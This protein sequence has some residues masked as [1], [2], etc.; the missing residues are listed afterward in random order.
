MAALRREESTAG[1]IERIILLDSALA[2]ATLRLVNS[3]FVASGEPI[4]SVEQAIV[5][6]GHRELYRIAS[7]S[8]L[9]RWEEHHHKSLPWEPGDYTR[10]SLCTALGA[11]VIAEEG[12]RFDPPMSYTVGLVCDVG[13]LV[14]AYVCAP[15]YS[16]VSAAVSRENLSWDEAERSVFG[17]DNSEVGAR[18]LRSWRFPEPFAQ[19]VEF[20]LHPEQAPAEVGPLVAQLHAARYVA[21]CMGPGVTA[22]G[23]LFNLRGAFLTEWGYTSEM[24]ER[25][26]LEVRDRAIARL[27]DRLSVGLV[28]AVG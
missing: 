21:V 11:E 27:G 28:K 17:Y 1:E 16:R 25:V 18:L 6:L 5:M 15:F 3:A 7:L 20:Q 22:G 23:F 24:L 8:L 19:A 2:A 10:H 4:G 12:D 14:M 9:S 13:K 26:M